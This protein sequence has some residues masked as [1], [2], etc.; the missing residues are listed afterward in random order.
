MEN[1]DMKHITDWGDGT[2]HKERNMKQ[3]KG[4]EAQL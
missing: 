2:I 4:N 3:I 1:T